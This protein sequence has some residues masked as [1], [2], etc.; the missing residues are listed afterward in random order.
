MEISSPHLCFRKHDDNDYDYGDYDDDKDDDDDDDDEHHD[1]L[2]NENSP[3]EQPRQDRVHKWEGLQ[4]S[5]RP[6]WS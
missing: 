5:R 4:S 3:L 2:K 1:N 6:P